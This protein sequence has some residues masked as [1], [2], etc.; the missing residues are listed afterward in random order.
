M[1][2]VLSLR[3]A[4]FWSYSRTLKR[5]GIC[6]RCEKC[7]SSLCVSKVEVGFTGKNRCPLSSDVVELAINVLDEE[8][9]NGI[10]ARMPRKFAFAA[11]AALYTVHATILHSRIGIVLPRLQ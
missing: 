3:G 1:Y 8:V 2:R 5:D 10:S 9:K 6:V 7:I 11:F 4:P